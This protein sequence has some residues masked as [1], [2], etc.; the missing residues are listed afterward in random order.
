MEF[1]AQWVGI[2]LPGFEEHRE[3]SV[4][5]LCSAVTLLSH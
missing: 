4:S 1:V 5:F 2:L 3:T